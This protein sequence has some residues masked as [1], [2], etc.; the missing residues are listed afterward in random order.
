MRR[1]IEV[2]G[3]D[4]KHRQ[5]YYWDNEEKRMVNVNEKVDFI[6]CCVCVGLLFVC[7]CC[8]LWSFS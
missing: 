7:V 6:T 8:W 2:Y 5:T 3:S 1:Y 4:G